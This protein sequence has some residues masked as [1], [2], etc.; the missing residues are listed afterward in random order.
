MLEIYKTHRCGSVAV[1]KW[2]YT[3]SN[4]SAGGISK[5]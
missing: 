4:N 5:F 1:K 3:E 2:R